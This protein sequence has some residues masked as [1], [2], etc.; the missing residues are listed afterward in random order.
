MEL[1][2]LE[3]E[4]ASP[5]TDLIIDLDHL[6]RKQLSGTT[7]EE[8]FF[9]LK[10]LFHML[11][12]I[13]SARIEGNNTTVASFVETRIEDRPYIDENIKEIRNIEETMEFIDNS[14]RERGLTKSY[15]K[16]LHYGIVKGL[17]PPPKG[18]GDANPGAFRNHGVEI[19]GSDHIPPE[20]AHEVEAYIDE[21]I[22]FINKDHPAKY[23]LLKVAI[24]HHRFMWIHPFGNGNGRTGRLLTYAM[25]VSQG[26]RVG[27]GRILNPTAVFCINRDI[28]NEQL[29]KADSNTSEGIESWCCYV[30][31]GLK[32]EIAKIDRLTDYSYLVRYI[33]KPSLDFSLK[34]K[35]V[36]EDEYAILLETVKKQSIQNSDIQ[37]LFPKEQS[38]SI[39]R[40]LR[41]LK[42][43]KM[44][45]NDIGNTRRYHISFTNSFLIRGIIPQLARNGFI[46]IRDD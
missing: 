37:A 25:L 1:K 41:H 34:Q 26:F 30:L 29:A 42:E 9:Q 10:Q 44:L 3:P 32:E 7:H 38:T 6:R 31:D 2:L 22:E 19:T 20:T 40:R 43:K 21:L 23:D 13:G 4:F 17:T 24:A 16:E 5:L 28:Y 33:L 15:L 18:E 8:V 39:S 35:L 27:E 45:A 46:P 14:I 12:S 11:E 36:N